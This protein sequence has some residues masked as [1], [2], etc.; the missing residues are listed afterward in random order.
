MAS[1]LK[2]IAIIGASG[3]IGKIILDG[4]VESSNF[5]VTVISRKESKATFPSGVTVVRTDLSDNGLIEAFKGQDAVISAVGA[6]GLGEQKKFVDASIRAGVKRFIPSEF[7]ASSQDKAVVGLLPLFGQKTELVEYLKSKE[8]DGLTWTG[9]A[10]SCLFDWGLANGFLEFDIA[11]RT[12]TIWDDG[13]KRFT[14]TNEKQLG[15][16]V[17]SVLQHPQETKNQYLYIASVETTQNEILASLE[18]ASG[19]KWAVTKTTTDTQVTEAV[20]KLTAGDF[21]GAFALVRST[22]FGN[23]QGLHANYAADEK[24]AND[25]LGLGL[26]DV[27]DV[28]KRVVNK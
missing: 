13:N 15:Q 20:K 25:M 23:T 8:S 26:E 3:N 12:A 17:A 4:L 1:P 9:I 19:E 2:N 10:T 21:S 16:A 5:N 6:T 27:K 7:S 14:L 24:L 22:T 28:V 11:N 18:E